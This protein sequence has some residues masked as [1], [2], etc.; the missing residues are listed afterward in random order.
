MVD[1]SSGTPF[2]DGIAFIDTTRGSGSPSVSGTTVGAAFANMDGR[3]RN[4]V[5]RYDSPRFAGLSMA[6]SYINGGDWDVA[7]DYKAKIGA[8]T[9]RL[10]AQYNNSNAGQSVGD[11]TITQD[12]MSVSGGALHSSGL[13]GS[14][15]YGK[16]QL[17]GSGNI[18]RG[19]NPSAWGFN[20]G[21]RAKI[22][23]A[24][25]TNFSFLWN[26]SKDVAAG[27]TTGDARGFTVAQIFNSIGANMAITYRNYSFDSATN[28]FDDVDIFGLQ[29]VFNF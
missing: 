21:Y 8:F 6:T 23:G 29:T 22:F 13:N 7:G 25:G 9:V 10:Q 17:G 24:G 11:L 12:S 19:G 3:S 27:N 26:H 28:T 15:F 5:L 2:G 14:A 16:Q 20:V 18:G 4:D 1:L